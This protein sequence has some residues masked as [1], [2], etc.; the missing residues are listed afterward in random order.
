M[1]SSSV[2]FFLKI[3]VG[4]VQ[5]GDTWN[6]PRTYDWTAKDHAKQIRS[7]NRVQF[8]SL[9]YHVPIIFP[10]LSDHVPTMFPSFSH[11]FLTMFP[12]F[13]HHCPIIFPSFSHHFPIIC[14]SFAHHFPIIFP[15]FSHH[16]PIIFPSFAH[17]LPIIFPSFAHHLP[18]IFPSF[19]LFKHLQMAIELGFVCPAV[20]SGRSSEPAPVVRPSR[21]R[22]RRA[23][24]KLP[25][26][27]LQRRSVADQP[28]VT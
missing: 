14:P 3:S 13:S 11:H 8:Q 18:I 17:H 28:V 9:N 7:E 5:L 24:S 25:G 12:P 20:A 15:S 4:R 16:F 2:P 1:P 19:S 21:H 6:L 27:S 22:S 23:A 26:P 10:P